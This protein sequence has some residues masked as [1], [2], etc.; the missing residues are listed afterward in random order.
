HR[1]ER[2]EACNHDGQ[3]MGSCSMKAAGGLCV[4]ANF[5]VALPQLRGENDETKSLALVILHY[6]FLLVHNGMYPSVRCRKGVLLS[7]QDCELRHQLRGRWPHGHRRAYFRQTLGQAYSRTTY[8]HS[9]EHGWWWGSH[10]SELPRRGGK[11]RRT[12]SRL[13]YRKPVST[14]DQGS[15]VARRYRQVWLHHG[16]SWSHHLLHALGCGTRY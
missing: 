12:H 14:P 13:L 6:C 11:A 16:C 10:C 3:V 8:H 9:A 15:C 7:G 5:C 4:P 2:D 1:F